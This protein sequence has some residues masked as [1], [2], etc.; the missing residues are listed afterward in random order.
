[1]SKEKTVL[2]IYNPKAGR[3]RIKQ[4]M[5]EVRRLFCKSGISPYFHATKCRGDA[6]E[7][8]C[9]FA[10]SGEKTC[11]DNKY[12][13][14]AGGDG[15]LNE[16]MR[17]VLASGKK[18]PIG[19]IPAGSTNDF[20]YSLG[21][22]GGEFD[23]AAKII[24]SVKSNSVFYCD[25][26]SFNK[27]YFT[28][29]AAFGLFSDVSY[30]TPQK[31]KNIFG[32]FA[33]ILYGAAGIF[34]SRRIRALIETGDGRKIEKD[35]LLGMVVSAK[36]VGGFRGITGD[37]VK[38]ND[39]MHELM[40]VVWP[41]NPVILVK[42]LYHAFLMTRKNKS[43]LKKAYDLSD[44]TGIKITKIKEADFK[45][46][47]DITWAVDGEDGGSHREVRISVQRKGIGY[48]VSDIGE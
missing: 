19:I 9:K 28:Y 5:P 35:L 38:L 21:I 6:Y 12:I 26:A 2:I 41:D 4:I 39:G 14:A 47:R 27:E 40:Y 1:M 48:L 34:R 31:I 43:A 3:G 22:N 23:A 29:T 18:I 24:D 20:G 42:T 11:L 10:L 37:G 32:H 13:V 16:V 30:A 45:F 44:D 17:G 25:T 33:Y 8:A 15:T 36:S 46:L 7:T